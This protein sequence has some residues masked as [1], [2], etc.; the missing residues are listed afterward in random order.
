MVASA[1]LFPE[2]LEQDVYNQD[3]SERTKVDLQ[4]VV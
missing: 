4:G 2:C 3:L 1:Q